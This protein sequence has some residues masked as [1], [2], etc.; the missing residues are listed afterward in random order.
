MFIYSKFSSFGVEAP[1]KLVHL[2]ANEGVQA[3]CLIDEFGLG[4]SAFLHTCKKRKMRA[5]IAIPFSSFIEGM[6]EKATGYF[7]VSH[8][9]N[10]QLIT[11]HL[12]NMKQDFIPIVTK[13][14]L[15]NWAKQEIY[16][17]IRTGDTY[18]EHQSK[19]TLPILPV[20]YETQ[21]LKTKVLHANLPLVGVSLEE[22]IFSPEAMIFVEGVSRNP[23]V[24]LEGLKP[25]QKTVNLMDYR[26]KRQQLQIVHSFRMEKEDTT[27]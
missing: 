5:S 21:T 19:A 16:C 11:T 9:D 12:Q 2:L 18:I 23:H 25:T 10:Y 15:T 13:E 1:E 3:L 24:F 20:A 22:C 14:Q 6:N 4:L 7:V 27:F 26:Q 8:C 17:L